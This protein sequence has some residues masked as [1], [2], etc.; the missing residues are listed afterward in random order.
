MEYT[1]SKFWKDRLRAPAQ[2]QSGKVKGW[3][4]VEKGLPSFVE[5]PIALGAGFGDTDPRMSDIILVSAPG[6]V[7][8]STLARQIASSTGA[9]LLDLAEADPV[10]ANTVVGGLAITGLYE[11]FRRGEASL[12]I[13]GLDEARMRVTQDSFA[14]FMRDMTE[15][16]GPEAKPIVLFGRTGAV[17]EA[18]V[19][20]NDQN[21][22][23][24]VLQIGYYDNDHAAEFTK[25]QA[26]H[27]RDE[28][29]RREPDG[30]AIDL[31]L[32]QLRVQTPADGGTFS[33]YAPVLV[34]VAKQVADPDAPANTQELISRIEQNL[35]QITL[36]GITESILGREQR[37]MDRLVL[38]D[39]TLRSKLY[40]PKEQLARLVAHIYKTAPS[41][42]L[43]H[44]SPMDQETYSNALSTWVTEHPFLDGD[45]QRPSSAVFG[46]F[47]ASEAI[48]SEESADVALSKELGHGTAANPFLAEFYI[49]NCRQNPEKPPLIAAEH[50]GVLYASLRA[51]LSL[52]Q[53]ANLRIDGESDD[54]GDGVPAELAEVEITSSQQIDVEPLAFVTAPDGHFRFGPKVESVDITAPLA[55]V[56]V[57]YG[58][59]AVFVAPVAIEANTV[60]ID[61][62][63]MVAETT[64]Q[65]QEVDFGRVVNLNAN[66]L[67]A[68]SLISRPICRGVVKLEVSWPG[69][70][71][72]PWTDFAVSV[73]KDLD[74]QIDEARRR[75]FKILVLFR[76]VNG[77]LAKA[78][79]AI[80]ARRRTKGMGRTVL[81]QLLIEEV[82]SIQ[83]SNY[84]LNPNRLAE[85]L[86]L[87]FRDVRTSTIN[88]QTIDFLNGAIDRDG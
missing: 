37:K 28:V 64:R 19:W 62:Q 51:R 17:Q 30:R 5:A 26:Q 63:R 54:A 45:G 36:K 56:S 2:G 50:V 7:G 70:N 43:P 53:T 75:L 42:T 49:S 84:I 6:A 12:I 74:H 38:E 9:M 41:F 79:V 81:E 21:I 52:G 67:E 85:I 72:Y 4:H 71:S 88:P 39:R 65:G 35:E 1:I 31:L 86:G 69:S 76:S 14:A 66:K 32:D 82:L 11:S 40:T 20:L 25:I 73:Q 18:W 24:P 48:C 55:Q 27:I 78:R 58:S 15:L 29:Y 22:E 60:S 80:D 34:A 87:S 46:G 68:S 47:I 8:K 13:D 10:G 23:A 16:T 33:G 77:Q 3:Q 59:E 44:M 61:A 57:G 83:G